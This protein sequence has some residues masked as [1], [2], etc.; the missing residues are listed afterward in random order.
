MIRKVE[1]IERGS[2]SAT[3]QIF[4]CSPLQLIRQEYPLSTDITL[5]LYVPSVQFYLQRLHSIPFNAM[6]QH[7]TVTKRTGTG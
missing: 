5:T 1:G 4:P 2:A 3:F 7:L 6:S